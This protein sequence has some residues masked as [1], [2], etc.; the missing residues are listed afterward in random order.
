M[1][2]FSLPICLILLRCLT[3]NIK[4]QSVEQMQQLFPDKLAVFS[5]INRSVDISFKKGVPYAEANEVSEMMVLNDDANGIYNKDKV[6][7]SDFNELEKVEAYTLVPDGSNTRKIKVTDFKTQSSSDQDIFYD[8]QKVTS[9]D[10]PQMMKG[11]VAHV[12]TE[13]YNKDIR[14]LSSFYFSNYL[15]V[16]NAT[17]SITFRKIWMYDTS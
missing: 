7:H 9:F 11:S 17:Y 16:H 8:D 13:H 15:P 4:A 1:K 6:Y 10:Y 5:N 2:K 14:F 3:A 12:E